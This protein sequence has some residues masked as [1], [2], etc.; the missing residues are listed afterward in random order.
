MIGSVAAGPWRLRVAETL[1]K[2]QFEA[3]QYKTLVS[4]FWKG[5]AV[6]K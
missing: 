3:G 1:P 5:E 2:P 4:D 6:P